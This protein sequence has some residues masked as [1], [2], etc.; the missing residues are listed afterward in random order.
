MMS[1]PRTSKRKIGFPFSLSMVSRLNLVIQWR[2]R[3]ALKQLKYFW[4]ALHLEP[5]AL[6]NVV[7][8]IP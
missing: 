5:D 1:P 3:V 4:F 6:Q 8:L 7:T 2:H